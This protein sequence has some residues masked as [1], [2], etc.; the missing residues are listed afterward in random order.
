MP[1]EEAPDVGQVPYGDLDRFVN[2]KNILSSLRPLEPGWY[3]A[4]A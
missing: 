3:T 1:E 4:A 2:V